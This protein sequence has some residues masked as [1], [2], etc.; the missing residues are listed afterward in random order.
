MSSQNL[1]KTLIELGENEQVEFKESVRLESIGK[2]VCAFLNTI[3]GQVLIGVED[4][5][6]INRS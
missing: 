1:I 4:N 2:D 6:R 5:G 3:G